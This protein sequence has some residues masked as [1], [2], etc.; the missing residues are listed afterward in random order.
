MEVSPGRPALS[1]QGSWGEVASQHEG[2]WWP[3]LPT[4]VSDA[5]K[6]WGVDSEL[7]GWNTFLNVPSPQA[8][9]HLR[10]S[11]NAKWKGWGE[12]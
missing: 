9:G 3:H 7:G 10:G 1:A 4:A 8:P 11:R 6:N 5:W 2:T 12:G